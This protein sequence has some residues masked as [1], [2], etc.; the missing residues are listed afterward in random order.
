MEAIPP[1]NLVRYTNAM[2]SNFKKLVI[3]HVNSRD[4]LREQLTLDMIMGEINSAQSTRLPDLKYGEAFPFIFKGNIEPYIREKYDAKVG[5]PIRGPTV[6]SI[7]QALTMVGANDAFNLERLEVIGDSFLKLVSSA[8]VYFSCP[9]LDEGRLSYLRQIQ[10]CNCNLYLIGC[11]KS[12]DKLIV[13]HK[14]FPNNNWLLPSY[15]IS[16]EKDLQIL[17]KEL[18]SKPNDNNVN[19]RMDSF[20]YRKI[21]NKS[22]ADSVEALIG[23][24]LMIGGN[25]TAL[26][27]MEWLGLK[28]RPLKDGVPYPID[29]LNERNLRNEELFQWL[30][31]PKDPICRTDCS[32]QEINEFFYKCYSGANLHHFEQIIGYEF[33]NKAYLIQALTHSSFYFN[34]YTDCYQKLEFLGDALIDYLI[35][36]HI[37]ATP[38]RNFNPGQLTDLRSALVNNA[39]FAAIAVKYKFHKFLKNFSQDLFRAINTFEQN[40]SASQTESVIESFNKLTEEE[41]TDIEEIEVPKAL[42]DIFESVAGAIFLDNGLSLDG[43]WKVYFKLLKPEIGK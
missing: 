19:K 34:Q 32:Q 37:F 20:K 2:I 33:R 35:S 16:D 15:D 26:I 43:L 25:K 14:W 23:A 38:N 13:S 30:P 10:I 39:F 9:E 41:C 24:H 3:N 28:V 18:K 40:F 4:Q 29:Y 31:P 1:L 27:F 8:F 11:E 5:D 17:Q 42:G 36:R 7:L 22:I 21:K 6:D 12:I